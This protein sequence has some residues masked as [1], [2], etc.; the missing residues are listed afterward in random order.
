MVAIKPPVFKVFRITATIHG[1][2]GHVKPA[3]PLCRVKNFLER[4]IFYLSREFLKDCKEEIQN[5]R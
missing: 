5:A 2:P 3:S 1:G 4:A